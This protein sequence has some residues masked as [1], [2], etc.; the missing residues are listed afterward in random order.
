MNRYWPLLLLGLALASCQGPRPAREAAVLDA[1]PLPA[2]RPISLTTPPRYVLSIYGVD[3]PLD[4]AVAPD[5]TR[6]YVSEGGGERQ[7]RIFD[8]DGQLLGTLAPPGTE[9]SERMPVY[10]SVAPNGQVYVSDRLAHQLYVFDPKGRLLRTI[11]PPARSG[12]WSPLGVHLDQRGQ[13][14]VTDL[15]AAPHQVQVYDQSGRYLR[16]LGAELAPPLAFPNGV[17]TDG[18]GRIYVADG[19]NRRVLVWAEGAA[20]VILGGLG[21]PRGLAVD[22]QQR[23]YVADALAHQ[24]LV[25]AVS[26]EPRPLFAF[27]HEGFGDGEFRFPNGVAVDRLNQVYVVDRENQRVQVWTYE[28]GEE[29]S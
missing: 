18:R 14:L 5:G 19:N 4:V 1:R 13:L 8:R 26:G 21:L 6:L 29:G 15:A 2:A 25:Y 9:P 10:L 12:P 20:P 16:S 11:S 28:G 17:T 7:V 3:H 22:S 24:V 23:L 27:G